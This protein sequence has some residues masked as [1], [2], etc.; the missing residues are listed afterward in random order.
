VGGDTFDEADDVSGEGT[1]RRAAG[2]LHH[3]GPRHPY[4]ASLRLAGAVERGRRKSFF[5][6]GARASVFLG[7]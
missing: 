2:A 5:W 3:G 6:R 4:S 1:E 7:F